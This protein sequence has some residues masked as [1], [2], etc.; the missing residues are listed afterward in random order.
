MGVLEAATDDPQGPYVDRG[1][2]Y[3][4]DDVAT[5]PHNRWAID[6]TVLDLRGQLYFLWSGWADQRDVQHLYIARMSDPCTIA[7]NRVQLCPN[8]CHP[9][10]RVGERHA[11][12]GL[13]EGPQVLVRNG[14][15]FLVYSC[16]GS[17]QPTYKL[18]LLHMDAA[19]DPIDPA[20]LAQARPPRLRIHP[21]RLRR[22]PLLLHDLARRHR[23][24]DPL[25]LQALP[26]GLLGPRGAGA[27]VH[28]AAGRLPRLR[29]PR[30]GAACTMAAP[31]GDG[32][33]VAGARAN[34][35]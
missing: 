35:A 11:E 8:D 12:R 7:S 20:L 34:A 5:G 24:L 15:V 33:D 25:P 23:G 31:S 32:L 18:G 16:S 21:R 30:P 2:L 27:A 17:W 4:G 10:E 29:P 13:H 9:W 14:R 19:A 22:R 1:M 26:L 28:L 3:T 6:G